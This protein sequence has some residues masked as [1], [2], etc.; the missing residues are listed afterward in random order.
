MTRISVGNWAALAAAAVLLLGATACNSSIDDPDSSESQVTVAS[1]LPTTACIDV[2]GSLDETAGT[3][4]YTDAAQTLTFESRVRGTGDVTAWMDVIL[5]SV[6][7]SYAMTDGGVVPAPFTTTIGA[8][9]VPAGGTATLTSF[10]TVPVGY[11]G[12]GAEFSTSGR[13]GTA[14]LVFHGRDAAGKSVTVR[15]TAAIG[16]YTI[17]ERS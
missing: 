15:G 17:C 5:T 14:T 13:Q 8:V 6:D 12:P 4:T 16:T 1:Y 11:I 10:R 3:T 2:D 9:T 7:V